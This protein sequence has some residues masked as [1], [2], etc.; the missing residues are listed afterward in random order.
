MMN[1]LGSPA[2]EVKGFLSADC[3]RNV[4]TVVSLVSRSIVETCGESWAEM[5]IDT[6]EGTMGYCHLCCYSCCK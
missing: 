6:K 2:P 4:F 3:L 1:T 5:Y